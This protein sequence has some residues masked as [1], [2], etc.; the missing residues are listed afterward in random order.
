MHRYKTFLFLLTIQQSRQS[1]QQI[2]DYSTTNPTMNLSIA[3]VFLYLTTPILGAITGVIIDVK[4]EGVD[5][6]KPFIAAETTAGV[7]LEESYNTVHGGAGEPS[8][9]IFHGIHALEEYYRSNDVDSQWGKRR[10]RDTYSSWNGQWA[11][12]PLCI[13]DDDQE[14]SMILGVN[15][16]A[17]LEA[18]ENG[19]A[20]GLIEHGHPVFQNVRR[21]NVR[22][23]VHPNAAGEEPNVDIGLKC[24]GL[25]MD[26]LSIPQGTFIAEYLQTT[27][28]E[29]HGKADSDGSDLE[30]V[31]YQ[32]V[33][34]QSEGQDMEQESGGSDDLDR[35]RTRDNYSAWNGQWACGALCIDDDDLEFGMLS[36]GNGGAALRAW[37]GAFTAALAEGSLFP[38]VEWCDIKMGL[39]RIAVEE[40]EDEEGKKA[41]QN[42]IESEVNQGM[43]SVILGTT[44]CFL[45]SCA[46]E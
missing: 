25:D 40:E 7:I 2:L 3:A 44:K 36:T 31:S 41:E 5:F 20:A 28:N 4:C 23:S 35:R 34:L 45:R 26:N 29:I 12:G 8:G 18:W 39:L 43:M 38:N 16:G 42:G 10:R 32:G 37:E 33:T 17:S 19:F 30:I 1:A 13:N 11:C 6:G 22:M 9:V 14:V 21:C 27:Y 24:K 15:S 46:E